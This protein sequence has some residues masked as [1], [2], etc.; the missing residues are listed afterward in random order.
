MAA[1]RTPG[2][3]DADTVFSFSLINAESSSSLL[4]QFGWFSIASSPLLKIFAALKILPHAVRCKF[5]FLSVSSQ[6]FNVSLL[7]FLIKFFGKFI[8][9]VFSQSFTDSLHQ[10]LIIPDIMP[11]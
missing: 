2:N 1:A 6:F 7:L 10:P 11:A 4:L 3:K 9:P 8:K 5:G